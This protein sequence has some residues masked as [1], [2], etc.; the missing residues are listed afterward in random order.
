MLNARFIKARIFS[1]FEHATFINEI[2]IISAVVFQ[3]QKSQTYRQSLAETPLR[4]ALVDTVA[5]T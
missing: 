5:N 3:A 2:L 4:C 1:I